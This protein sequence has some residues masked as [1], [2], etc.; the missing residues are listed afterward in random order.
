[1]KFNWGHGIALFFSVFVLT[2]VYFVYRST[3]FDNSLVATNYYALDLTYQ[4]HYDRL[5]NNRN[6][7]DDIYIQKTNSHLEL[8][9]P[10]SVSAISGEIHL[11]N[12]VADKADR[13]IPIRAGESHRQIIETDG[14]PSGRWRIKVNWEGDG[15]PYYREETL[16]L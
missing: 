14:L 10:E 13:R 12:I 2:L 3:Q 11:F 9:Y 4:E 5:V 6:L 16:M 7:Q 15:I 1:M 8:V